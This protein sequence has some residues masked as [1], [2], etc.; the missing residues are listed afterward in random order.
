M[1]YSEFSV[2]FIKAIHQ[3]ELVRNPD[4]VKNSASIFFGKNDKTDGSELDPEEMSMAQHIRYITG[5]KISGS[6][7]QQTY[8]DQ[9][10]RYLG[11]KLDNDP[12]PK[13]QKT[14][15]LQE[16]VQL[17]EQETSKSSLAKGKEVEM[18]RLD[19]KL[20]GFFGTQW[21]VYT[22]E[23]YPY[24]ETT[25][26][27]RRKSVRIWGIGK[28]ILTIHAKDNVFIENFK[29]EGEDNVETTDYYGRVSLEDNEVLGFWF[30]TE[31]E[32]KNLH[33]KVFVNKGGVYRMAVGIYVNRDHQGNIVAGTIILEKI[34]AGQVENGVKAEPKFFPTGSEH[35]QSIPDPIRDY[36]RDRQY[37]HLKVPSGITNQVELF[38][39]LES[40]R[41]S[42]IR[43]P[44][45][46]H[47]FEYDVFIA[48]PITSLSEEEREK[49]RDWLL[50]IETALKEYRGFKNIFCANLR[51][52]NKSNRWDPQKISSRGV[53][54]EIP[55]SRYF[56]LV[57]VEPVISSSLIETGWALGSRKPTVVFYKDE[58]QLPRILH[59]PLEDQIRSLVSIK[60]RQVDKL[61]DIIEKIKNDDA[62]F[63]WT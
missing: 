51:R 18:G 17:M 11:R 32:E 8:S 7:L 9:V 6:T 29:M 22:Y 26:R 45:R 44:D 40:K 20:E 61:D 27:K 36:L 58:A 47:N 24:T 23:E 10:V 15:I 38:E 19:K 1:N 33:I 39:W 43:V 49:Q 25:F 5:K 50:K 21:Q 16:Y 55:R 59:R 57:F 2:L 41:A 56:M 30:K 31:T 14:D 3:Y 12:I 63:N 42:N 60:G 34:T 28:A 37:N 48:S 62:L 13:N 46:Y 35:Y 52:T 4:K 53:L 54:N